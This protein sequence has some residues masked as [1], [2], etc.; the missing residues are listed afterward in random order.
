M[1]NGRIYGFATGDPG[2]RLI[3]RV[4]LLTSDVSRAN[5]MARLHK[6]LIYCNFVGGVGMTYE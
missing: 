1:A 3:C 4:A 2:V 6:V 5:A